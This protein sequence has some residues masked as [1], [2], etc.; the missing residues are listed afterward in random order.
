MLNDE[1]VLRNVGGMLL[2]IM[3]C[4]LAR[5]RVYTLQ[6][7]SSPFAAFASRHARW[8]QNNNQHV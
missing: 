5:A 8:F 1:E 7:G 3:T 6:H 4:V 2:E